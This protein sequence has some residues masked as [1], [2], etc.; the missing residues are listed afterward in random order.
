[1]RAALELE[2]TALDGDGAGLGAHEG[3]TVTVPGALPGERVRAAIE[4]RSP[5]RPVAWASLLRV[6]RPSPARVEP[7][8]PAFGQCGG[9]TLQH[10]DLP[11][12]LAF[13]RRRVCDALAADAPELEAEV[14]PVTRSPRPLG[15]RNREKL[16]VARQD[17]RVIL[18]AFKPH[19]H[20]VIDLAG[21][22]VVEAPLDQVARSIARLASAAG[23]DLP[24]Y[25]EKARTGF[26]RYVLLRTNHE[27]RVLCLFVVASLTDPALSRL[28]QLAEELSQE[29][30]QELTSSPEPSGVVSGVVVH[31]N[32]LQ[33]GALLDPA[34]PSQTLA[35][36]PTLLDRVGDLEIDAPPHAFLQVQRAQAAVL[37]RWI[38][39]AVGDAR[40]VL[41][42]YA[43]IGA[44]AVALAI[45]PL[46]AREVIAVELHPQSAQA[47]YANAA[48]AGV[49]DRVRVVAQSAAAA[50]ADLAARGERF[51]VVVVDPPRKGLTDALT[52]LVA[53]GA[54]RIV[55][56]S[57]DPESLAR[58]LGALARAGYRLVG[59]L[60]PLDLF[61]GTPHVETVAILQR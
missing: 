4:H 45:S 54:P 36:S 8:C 51:D 9:C 32:R 28:K 7:A 5:H 60:R 38:D 52:P 22:R 33:S 31:E 26:L 2:I 42:G 23:A 34:G 50:F 53:L 30:S 6:L 44:E 58:D 13:K 12:Q 59:P 3:L 43:G 48:R 55:Y 17:G 11:A 29:R 37:Y 47:I 25:D 16:V 18:G 35:G 10:L 39:E 1:M 46:G 56:V 57:C 40:R 19:S 41:D 24:V 15:Y 27:G 20:E 14:D 61:P 21:C 49:V